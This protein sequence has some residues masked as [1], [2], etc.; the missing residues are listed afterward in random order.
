MKG[1]EKKVRNGRVRESTRGRKPCVV[2]SN[3][4]SRGGKNR[5]LERGGKKGENLVYFLA[6]CS[7]D[8]LLCSI[9]FIYFSGIFQ[10]FFVSPFHLLP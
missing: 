10:S 7:D 4:Q 2:C 9:F 1:R 8:S 5:R 6:L 3:S